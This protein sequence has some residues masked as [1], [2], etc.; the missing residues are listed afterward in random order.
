VQATITIKGEVKRRGNKENLEYATPKLYRPF[1]LS[2]LA[3][4]KK[5]MLRAYHKGKDK[6]RL[7]L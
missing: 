4:K 2:S 1:D 5:K 6:W 7:K 3:S